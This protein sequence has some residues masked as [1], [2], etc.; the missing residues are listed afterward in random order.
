MWDA[1]FLIYHLDQNSPWVWSF[2]VHPGCY[3]KDT[4][5]WAA[6]KNRNL[7]VTVLEAGKSKIKVLADLMSDEGHLPGSQMAFFSLCSQVL[8][9]ERERALWDLFYK[10]TN[11]I[12][13]GSI[14]MT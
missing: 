13:G 4:I 3:N 11:P 6:Y 1:S 9:G 12:Q 7:F 10:G 14:L 8:E 5:G 2:L